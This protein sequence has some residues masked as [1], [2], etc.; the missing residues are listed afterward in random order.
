MPTGDPVKGVARRLEG[1]E[2]RHAARMLRAKYP[3]MHGVLV[4]L[5]HRIG[6]AKTGRTVHF[7][8]RPR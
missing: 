1:T 5:S 2:S 7:E 3:F 8:V 6:R 4:P